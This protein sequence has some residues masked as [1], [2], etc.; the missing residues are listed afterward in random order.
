MCCSTKDT[1]IRNVH[2]CV[3][4]VHV[5]ALAILFRLCLF[6]HKQATRKAHPNESPV[7]VACTPPSPL[8]TTTKA[9]AKGPAYPQVSAPPVALK[10][11]T[12]EGE[13]MRQ[14]IINTT[15]D[16]QKFLCAV[17]KLR[18]SMEGSETTLPNQSQPGLWWE[19]R[20]E[21]GGE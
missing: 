20:E 6:S 11:V 14:D 18:E 2:G 15:T 1:A 21:R 19:G 13:D 4:H 12:C 16:V 5:R 3:W 9:Q 10:V 7:H 8:V 17:S